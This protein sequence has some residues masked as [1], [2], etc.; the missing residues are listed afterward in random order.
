MAGSPITIYHNARCS[1]SRAT[2]Q[3]LHDQGLNPTVVDYLQT[4]PSVAELDMLCTALGGEPTQ[5]VRFNEQEA[6]DL[7]LKKTDT[8]MRADWLKLL[9]ENP[10]LIERPIVLRGEHAV[11]GRPPENVKELL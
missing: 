1:K 7:G 2:L 4:P 9:A 6:K 3:L 5:M 10:R 8:R 11:I